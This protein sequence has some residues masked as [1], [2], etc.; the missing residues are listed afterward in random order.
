LVKLAVSLRS[1]GVDLRR[2]QVYRLL[3][4]RKGSADGYVRIVDGSGEDYLYPADHFTIVSISSEQA[5][6]LFKAR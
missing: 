3:P 5:M 4:D 1:R 6:R 2:G